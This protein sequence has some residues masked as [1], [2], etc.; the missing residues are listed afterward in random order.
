[1]LVDVDV[2]VLVV[3][4]DLFS[5]KLGA[6]YPQAVAYGAQKLQFVVSSSIISC[7]ACLD[8]GVILKISLF[9][10]LRISTPR[11][12]RCK[13]TMLSMVTFCRCVKKLKK[14]E[15]LTWILRRRPEW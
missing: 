4:V 9:L 3:A 2:V 5:E 7:D 14:F 6:V 12:R 1:L 11:F 10:G 15:W 8:A 13:S